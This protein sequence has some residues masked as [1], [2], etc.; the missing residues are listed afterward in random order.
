MPLKELSMTATTEAWEWMSGI[1]KMQKPSVVEERE[2][3]C[4]KRKRG[5]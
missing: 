2:N 5:I 4:Q 1:M 3:G